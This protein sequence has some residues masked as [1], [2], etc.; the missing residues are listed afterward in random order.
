[1]V[2]KIV[3]VADLAT[4]VL[5]VVI[6]RIVAD[7]VVV[8]VVGFVLVL[9]D[10]ICGPHCW[11]SIMRGPSWFTRAHFS[12]PCTCSYSCNR[13]FCSWLQYCSA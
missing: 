13:Y 2:F 4:V 10:V 7:L 1:M 6:L 5:V 8:V 12:F 11:R 9:L 3:I